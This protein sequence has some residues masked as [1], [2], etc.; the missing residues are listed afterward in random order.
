MTSVIK[1][2]PTLIRPADVRVYDDTEDGGLKVGVAVDAPRSGSRLGFGLKWIR[3]GTER[4]SWTADDATHEAYFVHQGSLEITWD[5][6][7]AGVAVVSAGEC[8]Y[9][10][11]GRT[12]SIENVGTDEVFAIWAS[13]PPPGQPEAA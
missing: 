8:F 11:P 5:G 7:P 1:N 12:Y 10:A 2:A 4:V 9:L 6:E 3:P 13:T